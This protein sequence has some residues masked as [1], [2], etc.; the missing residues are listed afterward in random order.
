M[1]ILVTGG[2]GYLGNILVN[3]L[4]AANLQSIYGADTNNSNEYGISSHKFKYNKLT[5]YDSLMYRQVCLTDYMHRGD[6]EF[7]HGDVRDQKKLLTYIKQADIIIPLAAIVG[8]PACEK[9][10]KLAKE[11][12]FEQIQFILENTTSSQQII[13]PNTNSGY[14]LGHGDLMCTEDMPLDPIS[15]YGKTKCAA[16]QMLLD[17]GRAITLRLATVFGISPRMRLDLLVNDFTYKAVRDKY[18]VLFEKDFKR[19]FIHIQDVGLTFIFM[20]NEYEK[21][22]GN[23]FNVG[24]T[25][26]NISKLELAERIKKYIPTFSIQTDEFFEDPDKRNYIV[27]NK[28]LESTGWTPYYTLDNGIQDLIKAYTIILNSDRKFTNL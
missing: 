3:K 21:Y 11:I 16:E 15:V 19:N 9:D 5:V 7:V 17:S 26:E 1:N 10:P 18:I 4:I 6:F 8:F 24:L 25:N 28:K 20:M 14:G 22:I 27:S 2:A 13:F 12:N 23:A